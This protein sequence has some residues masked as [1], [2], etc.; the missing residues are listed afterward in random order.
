MPK[1][2]HILLI[3]GHPDGRDARFIHALAQAYADGATA[4]G[5]EVRLI[6][7][8]TLKFD[9]LSRAEDFSEGE[10]PRAIS[11]AQQD[12]IWADHI[13]ILFPLWLGA[14]PALLKGFFEQL[15]RPGFAFKAAR[16]GLPKKLLKGR[17]ARVVVTMGMP[18]LFYK[19]VYRAHSLKS[20][21]R[22]ILSFCGITP[23]RSTVVGM[24]EGMG[25]A[26]RAKWLEKMAQFGARAS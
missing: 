2:K 4:A 8:G 5:H 14:M 12:V 22:N 18:G 7:V 25:A 6:T 17:S 9:L 19:L 23:V 16:K 3:N 10:P 26:R 20:L 13:V 21:E 24:V 15:L 1:P 11:A